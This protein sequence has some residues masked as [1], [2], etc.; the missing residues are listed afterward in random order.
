MIS[1]DV[2]GDYMSDLD[3]VENALKKGKDHLM[4]IISKSFIMGWYV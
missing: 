1:Y 4:I 3:D 2:I